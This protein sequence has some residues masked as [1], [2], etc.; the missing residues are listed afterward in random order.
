[1][2]WNSHEFIWLDWV[3][4]IV[5]MAA[6]IWAVWRAVQKDKRMQQGASSA[7]YLF[8]KGEPW[9]IIGAAIFAANIGSEH[10]VGLAGTGAKSGVGMAHWEMQGWMILLLGWLFVPFYQLLNNKMGKII[11][12]PDFLKYRY[13][14]RT[15][16][17]LSIITLIAYILTKVSV[18]AYTGGIFLEFLLGLPFWYGAIGLI[19]LTGLFHGIEWYEGGNDPFSYPD[20]YSNYRFLSRSVP[21]AVSSRWWKYRY[22]LD[23]NDGTCPQC[24]E[25]RS[26]RPC[27]RCQPHVP[28]E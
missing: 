16:S 19:V 7:D 2:N 28:L 3:I 8:G 18:T 26:R 6:V 9:Y 22:R 11:T 1:M 25:C 10:L 23:R 17:W 15:G 12:M 5:G 13:T 27:I 21:G 4:L 20:P 14:Q 24:H